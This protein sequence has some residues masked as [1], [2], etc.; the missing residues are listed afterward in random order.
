MCICAKILSTYY[1][2]TNQPANISDVLYMFQQLPSGVP[3]VA[4]WCKDLSHE[5]AGSTLAWLSGLK[6]SGA[7]QAAA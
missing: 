6:G 3:L 7:D 2:S 5:Y 4:Q 1:L